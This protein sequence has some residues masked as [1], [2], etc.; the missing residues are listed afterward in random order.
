MFKRSSSLFALIV[1]ATVTASCTPVSEPAAETAAKT[2]AFRPA[3]DA[4]LATIAARDL[5]GFDKTLTSG[6]DLNV[7]FPNGALAPDTQAVRE[8]HAEWFSDKDWVM[9]PEV[10][11]V[12][13][14]KDMATALLKYSYRDNAKSEPR[15]NWL[16]LV[17]KLEDGAW[18]LVHDQ[19]T[20][21]EDAIVG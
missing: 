20:K 13:E 10:I 5:E 4:H 2:P 1:V 21:I 15:M 6:D 19:N 3:L 12:I 18:K 9:E 17:F 7:I 11:K 16:V 14:G 8:F